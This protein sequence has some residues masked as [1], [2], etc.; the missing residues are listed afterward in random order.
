MAEESIN[1][2]ASEEMIKKNP[3]PAT[4]SVATNSLCSK[5]LIFLSYVLVT[6]TF[7][8]SLL[9]TIKVSIVVSSKSRII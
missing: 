5:L 3:E 7:P 6:F 4:E 9:F 8:L 2:E 1:M